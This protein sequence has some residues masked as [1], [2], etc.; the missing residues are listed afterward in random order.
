MVGMSVV[1][2]V[3]TFVIFA[4]YGSLASWI[5]YYLVGSPKIMQRFQR[6]FALIF[7]ALAVKLVLSEQ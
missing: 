2:M 4:I 5:S 1:F 7:A 6:S 3:M